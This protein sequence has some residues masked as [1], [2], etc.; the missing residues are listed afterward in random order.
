V[1]GG[2]GDAKQQR[3]MPRRFQ[4]AI[5]R[6]AMKAGKKTAGEYVAEWRRYAVPLPDGF[7][8]DYAAAVLAE[9]QRLEEDFPPPRLRELAD[10]GGWDH[11]RQ[12]AAG[13]GSSPSA[14][15]RLP[16]RGESR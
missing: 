9:A 14:T 11:G 13:G 4:A 1:N 5:D 15:A 12:E 6:A 2:A 16:S 3:L 10:A 7:D 8:G